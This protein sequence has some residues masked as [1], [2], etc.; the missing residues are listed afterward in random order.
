[1]RTPRR[2]GLAMTHPS[3]C[4][5]TSS[6]RSPTRCFRRSRRAWRRPSAAER[7]GR[8]YWTI[9]QR[10]GGNR[11]KAFGRCAA[12]RSTSFIRRS[13]LGSHSIARRM[14]WRLEAFNESEQRWREIADEI[15]AEVCERGFDRDLNSF[16]QAYGSKRL[17]ASLLLIPLVGFLPASRSASPGNASGDRGQT[18]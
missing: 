18:A 12:G 6:A 2:C 9:W 1:M 13:W 8:L 15:H 16:V 5:S 14:S 3:S 4:S 10:L 17:D 7:C 11:T